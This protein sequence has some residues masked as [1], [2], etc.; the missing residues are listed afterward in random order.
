LEKPPH[1]KEKKET[2]ERNVWTL[3]DIKGMGN[4]KDEVYNPATIRKKGGSML[5]ELIKKW[6]KKADKFERLARLYED[7]GLP[8]SSYKEE[9]LW[10]ECETLRTCAD[11]LKQAKKKRGIK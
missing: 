3:Y 10:A 2:T 6:Q 5:A 4:K 9:R 11:E 1:E 8:G 7:A